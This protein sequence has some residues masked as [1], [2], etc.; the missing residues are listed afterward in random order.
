MGYTEYWVYTDGADDGGITFSDSQSEDATAWYERESADLT[1]L[2]KSG[3]I[4]VGEIYSLH[5]AHENTYDE[6]SCAQYVTDHN[7]DFRV[8]EW[9]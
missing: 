7:P 3:Q 4:H 9:Q 1:A 6:C 2:V 5:H 8:G